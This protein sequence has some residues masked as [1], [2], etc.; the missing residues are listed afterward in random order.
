M[1]VPSMDQCAACQ[2]RQAAA[3]NRASQHPVVA[4]PDSARPVREHVMTISTW[5]PCPAHNGPAG[6]AR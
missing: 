2:S 5:E 3:A 4:R 6:G 1:S